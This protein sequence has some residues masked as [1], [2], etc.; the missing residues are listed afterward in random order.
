MFLFLLL[1]ISISCYS[2]AG[3]Q[4]EASAADTDIKSFSLADYKP[5]VEL[6]VENRTGSRITQIIAV[7]LDTSGEPAGKPQEFIKNIANKENT[8]INLKRETLYSITLI[9][10]DG[11]KY[12]KSRQAWDKP[13][14][15]IEFRQRNVQDRDLWDVVLR[16][17]FW[18]M[19]L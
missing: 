3:N 11:R 18:P 8:K 19:Y 17:V 1:S 13:S 2:C 5:G 16:L 6:T 10:A 4:E 14:A 7:A 12:I 15:E 9:G